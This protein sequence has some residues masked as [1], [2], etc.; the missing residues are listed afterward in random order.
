MKLSKTTLL[1]K[2]KHNRKQWDSTIESVIIKQKENEL[3]TKKWVLK[4]VVAHITW[5]EKELVDALEKK[6]IV[7]SKFWNMEV[8]P[9]NVEIF[10]DTQQYTLM[11]LI[12]ESRKTFNELVKKI[13]SLSDE[14]LNSENY[15]KQKEGTRVTHDYIGGITFWHYEEH[16]DA[17]I[18][19]FDLDYA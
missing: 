5:Y 18:D 9:R 13:E 3:V 17:L 19:R 12:E 6:S 16:Q 1:K 14:Q 8:E 4:D 15:I 10:E 7:N 11:D 2:L